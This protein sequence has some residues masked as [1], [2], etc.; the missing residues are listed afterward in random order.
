M[1]IRSPVF[2]SLTEDGKDHVLSLK[3][4]VKYQGANPNVTKLNND[5]S[6]SVQNDYS[7]TGVYI[8]DYSRLHHE[9]FIKTSTRVTVTGAY[10]DVDDVD[11]D[12]DEDVDYDEAGEDDNVLV[13][14]KL[15]RELSV[16]QI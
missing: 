5:A 8:C 1:P 11:D 15:R 4:P 14:A 10:N 12:D 2:F 7:A 13:H 6:L 9:S 3:R 16:V